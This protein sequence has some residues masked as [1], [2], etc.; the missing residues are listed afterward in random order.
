[1][2]T[3]NSVNEKKTREPFFHI[4]KNVSPTLR[5]SVGV[6]AGAI[7]LS[8][9][10][11]GILTFLLTGT[12]PFRMYGQMFTGNFGTANNT[13]VMLQNLAFLLCVSL[14]VTPAFKMKFWNTGAEGQALMGGLATAVCMYYG[15]GL[16]LF[17]LIPLMFVSAM[18]AG[19]L[20]AVIPAIF[21]AYF[22]TN[23]TLFTLMMNYVAMQLIIF[24]M[25]QWNKLSASVDSSQLDPSGA[26]GRFFNGATGVR[27]YVIDIAVV[28]VITVL[29]Y[30]YLRYSKHGYELSVVGES[31]NTARCIGI[32]VKKVIIRTM[33]LSGLVAGVCG[34]LLVGTAQNIS[35]SIVD[36]RGFTAIMVSW[37]A[38]FNPVIMIFA[39][40]LLVFLDIGALEVSSQSGI[41]PSFPDIITGIILFFIIG[42]EF[43]IQYKLVPTA[44]FMKLAE[45]FKRHKED[46]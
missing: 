22:N 37:L 39:S 42:C 19:A 26:I 41:A 18:A 6:R 23:E 33:A 15:K 34:F 35:S 8:L 3:N 21:K 24:F 40:F 10:F 7:L 12:N 31:Q 28:V 36:G 29:M 43:F 1:M 9:L 30:V 20:W 27:K 17:V 46:A 44:R 11:C 32:D 14:A 2:N 4:E 5:K 25:R 16:P 45:K 38:K 13:W